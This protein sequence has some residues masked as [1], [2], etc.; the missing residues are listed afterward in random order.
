[1]IVID[2]TDTPYEFD[3]IE[4]A[5]YTPYF[6]AVI[7]LTYTPVSAVIEPTYTPYPYPI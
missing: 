1:M 7:V 3:V 4:V 6:S 2:P 5:T